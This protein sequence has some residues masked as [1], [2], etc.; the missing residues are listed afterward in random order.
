MPLEAS[1]TLPVPIRSPEG[2][3]AEPSSPF[4]TS[5]GGSEAGRSKG[6]DR[7]VAGVGRNRHSSLHAA[8]SGG[9]DASIAATS[10][11]LS[12]AEARERALPRCLDPGRSR[13]L[14]TEATRSE[15]IG[16]SRERPP[17]FLRGPGVC[18]LTE[19]SLRAPSSR[20]MPPA[21]EPPKW[22]VGA[23]HA[24]G[25][26]RRLPWGSVP[27]GV[28]TRAIVVPVC[29]SDTVRS[30][31]FSPS[32]RFEPARASWLCF[33]PHPPIGFR[34]SELF[35]LSQPEHLSMPVALLPFRLARVSLEL[36]RAPPS[37]LP[38]L[39]FPFLSLSESESLCLHVQP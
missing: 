11:A 19:V 27:F 21:F 38:S 10:F 3:R 15:A 35:P 24:A 29:L 32:Q 13:S 5:R 22:V 6:S 20:R 37:P 28:S 30:Q 23:R 34:P 8:T 17:G 16:R 26:R 33:A 31:G 39:P 25:I 14:G 9:A 2:V 4:R 7:A 12:R 36:P 18:R 1:A